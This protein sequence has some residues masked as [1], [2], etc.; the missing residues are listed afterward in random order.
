MTGLARADAEFEAKRLQIL[1]EVFPRVS[2]VAYLTNPTW[3]PQYTLN[4]KSEM[5]KAARAWASASDN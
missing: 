5:E 4:S 2:H 3:C 1:K